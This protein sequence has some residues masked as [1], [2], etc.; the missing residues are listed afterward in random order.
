MDKARG[1]SGACKKLEDVIKKHGIDKQ[2]GMVFAHAAA[3]DDMEH[4]K[5]K[6]ETL[7]EGCEIVDSTIG[8]VIGTHTGPGAVGFAFITP[9]H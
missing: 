8:A 1:K 7:T 5:Q 4:L 9:A 3:P 6:L 2:Y